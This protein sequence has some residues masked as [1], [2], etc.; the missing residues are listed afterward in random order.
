M[1]EFGQWLQ[2]IETPLKED[3]VNAAL[4]LQVIEQEIGKRQQYPDAFPPLTPAAQA[5]IQNNVQNLQ[6][7]LQQQEN[8]QTGRTGAKE[9][10]FEEGGA[11]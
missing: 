4:R 10:V 11:Q 1:S 9:S 5:I 2:G 6:F 8:A 3:G 7:I